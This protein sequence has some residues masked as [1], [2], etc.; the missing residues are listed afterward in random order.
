M[1]TAK[2]IK[3]NILSNDLLTTLIIEIEAAIH[4]L[5]VAGLPINVSKVSDQL[6]DTIVSSY[7]NKT[8]LFIYKSSWC[9]RIAQVLSK[10]NISYVGLVF[11]LKLF[12]LLFFFFRIKL[13]QIGKISLC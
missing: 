2:E 1:F 11:K 4:S 3:S 13:N 6:T 9:S 8:S 5:G 7:D 10:S 12:L